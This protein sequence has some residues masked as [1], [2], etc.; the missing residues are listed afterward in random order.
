MRRTL[1]VAIAGYGTAGELHARLLAARPH[2]RVVGVADVTPA[3]RTS[4]AAA[5]PDA[6]VAAKLD[7]LDVSI[8]LV[9]VATPPVSHESDTLVALTQHHGHV[10]C[11]KPAVL[12]PVRGRSLAVHA[13][14]ASLLLHPVHNYVYASGFRRMKELAELGAI[15]RVENITIEITRTAAAIGNAAWMPSWRTDPAF[16]GGILRDHGP[17][18]IY[19]ACHLAGGLASQVSCTTVQGIQGVDQAATI[20]LNIADGVSARINLT[21]AGSHRSNRYEVYGTE[22]SLILHGGR[23]RLR[24]P[25]QTREW[26]AEDPAS[27]G[28]AHAD[29]LD[30]LHS[31]LLAQIEKPGPSP[32]P[33][34]AAI[35]VAEVLHAANLSSGSGGGAVRLVDPAPAELVPPPL[36]RQARRPDG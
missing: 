20:Q 1:N 24:S 3:R 22:G 15:G 14:D 10:L 26:P 34:R 30:A 11:E 19:L 27:G 4:A 33:W 13:A 21:W 28:H 25:D 2:I 5:Y 7:S 23:L 6:A 32:D 12:N 36:N 16:G 17:H 9:V 31:D 29:W 35:H 8:D 18:A